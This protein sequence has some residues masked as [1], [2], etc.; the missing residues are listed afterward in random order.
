MNLEHPV[1][2]ESKEV[3][4]KTQEST[5]KAPNGPNGNNWSSKI[6]KVL[7]FNP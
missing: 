2:P 7:N 1:M 5:R 3:P 6:M 4:R